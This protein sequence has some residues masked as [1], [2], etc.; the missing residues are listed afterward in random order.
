[1]NDLKALENAQILVL[2]PQKDVQNLIKD[3]N[4]S[5]IELLD[6]NGDLAIILVKAK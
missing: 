5:G 3:N 2:V 1:V 4:S 6:E